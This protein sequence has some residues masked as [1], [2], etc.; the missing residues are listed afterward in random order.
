V[1]ILQ[2]FNKYKFPGG[3]E[4]SVLRVAGTLEK[5]H[6]VVRCYFESSAWFDDSRPFAQ[7]RQAFAMFYNPVAIRRVMSLIEK[8]KPDLIII[9]NIFPICSFG[10]LWKIVRLPIP[11]VQYIHNFRP[12]SVNGYSWGKGRILTKGFHLNF[13]PEILAGSWQDSQLKTAW[14][15]IIILCSHFTGCY[16]RISGWL[17]IS[18]FMKEKFVSGG[19]DPEKITVLRHSWDSLSDDEYLRRRKQMDV[20]GTMPTPT[21]LFMGRISQEKGVLTLVDAWKAISRDNPSAQ[22]IVCGSGPLEDWLQGQADEIPSLQFLGHVGGEKK[23]KLLAECLAVVVPSVWWEPLGIVV[24]E[25]YDNGKP[26]LAAASGG[27]TETVLDGITGLL[28]QPG[29]ALCLAACM[30]RLMNNPHDAYEMGQ[31]GREFLLRAT[32]PKNWEQ[33]IN[34]AFNEAISRKFTNHNENHLVRDAQGLGDLAVQPSSP[35]SNLQSPISLSVYLA[36]QNP[37]HDRSFGISRMTQVVLEALQATGRVEIVTISSQTSQQ[38]PAHIGNANILPWG[39]RRKWV[40]L[41]TDHLHPL[42]IGGGH[43]GQKAD[44]HYFPKGYLPYFSGTRT[45][46]VVT[47]HDTIIQ[48]DQ[49]CYPNWRKRWEYRYW[50]R[51][52]KHTL[53]N[54]DRIITV[55]QTSKRQIEAFMERHG[56]PAQEITVTYEPCLYESIPQ[57]VSGT[58]ENFV[59]HLASCE[60]HKRTAHL[61]RWWLAAEAQG[62]QLPTLHLIGSVPMEVMPML[63]SAKSIVKRP[64]LDEDALQDA[65]LKASA[66]ILPSEI[67]GFGLPAL[68]AYYLG[69][70]VCYVKGTSVEEILS[71]ATHKGGFNLQEP[72]SLFAALDEVMSMS[73]EELRSCGLKLRETYAAQK[74]ANRM[75]EVFDSVARSGSDR[76]RKN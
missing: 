23:Q 45:P 73:A 71:V 46:S 51:I 26:V 35:I 57:P 42:F 5:H 76:R 38:A 6:K 7:V 53:H 66:L 16:K 58:K 70:P 47:I 14:Y 72:Q 9:H 21:F 40:R 33:S 52:L 24:Y 64:F 49:D 30:A 69:T 29:D 18:E 31:R 36:D 68:E 8:E 65:Y 67:E 1:T 75:L 55:S 10:M 34:V 32:S 43:G 59:I 22:L 25:A 2:I 41:M 11:V 19:I 15:A 39:T 48:H 62:Q 61:I 4:A 20:N 27:L 60:P 3:E 50:A 28:H 44:V 17:A 54:A 74:V 56:I 12:F 37:G 13:L 63:A